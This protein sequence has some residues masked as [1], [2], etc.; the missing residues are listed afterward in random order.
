[1]TM[2][3]LRPVE[4]SIASADILVRRVPQHIDLEQNSHHRTAHS[5][6]FFHKSHGL[7][8]ID[9]PF[10]SFFVLFPAIYLLAEDCSR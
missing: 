3:I 1:M 6:F 7:H 9:K 2:S 4:A 10:H 5:I 8:Y